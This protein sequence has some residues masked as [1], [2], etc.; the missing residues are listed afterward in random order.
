MF[1]FP[2]KRLVAAAGLGGLLVAGSLTS[3][4]TAQA[5]SGQ[6]WG[7]ASQFISQINGARAANHRPRLAV[8]STLTSVA[9]GW[10]ASMARSNRLAHNP[11]LASSVHGWTYLGENV[12]VGDSVS[13]LESAFWDSAGHRA[14]MLDTDFTRVGVAAV[15]TGGRLWVVEEFMRPNGSVASSR[16]TRSSHQAGASGPSGR[17]GRP[18]A[19]RPTALELARSRLLQRIFA[20]RHDSKT[21][22][23]DVR[24]VH[25]R[26]TLLH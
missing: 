9:A 6:D 26:T 18:A 20:A 13:Q 19:H 22:S 15:S 16:P 25:N 1:T 24:A 14:N 2:I 4:A 12:G 23:L 17:A 7:A 5:A 11:R 3:G 10:A 21:P 8:S